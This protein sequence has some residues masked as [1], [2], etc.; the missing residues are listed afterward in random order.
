MRRPWAAARL[1][2]PT[3]RMRLWAVASTIRRPPRGPPWAAARATPPAIRMQ[4]WPAAAA[5]LYPGSG[6]WSNASDRNLKANFAPVDDLQVLEALSAMPMQTW[7]YQSQAAGI[8]HLGPMAQ[9]FRAAF[10]LGENDTTISTVDA[11]GVA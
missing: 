10:G 8:R 4:R 2:P 6:S 5:A 7:N 3:A 1:T 11:Q 9:D